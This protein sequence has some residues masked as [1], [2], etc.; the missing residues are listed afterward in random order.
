[1]VRVRDDRAA[2]LPQ[3]IALNQILLVLKLRP[4]VARRKVLR[5]GVVEEVAPLK[6]HLIPLAPGVRVVESDSVHRGDARLRAHHVLAHAV[7]AGGAARHA[8]N[9][10]EREV[11]LV[12]VV[13]QADHRQ[14]AVPAEDVDITAGQVFA[15]RLGS[16]LEIVAVADVHLAELT[17]THVS[18]RDDVDRLVALA[19]VHTRE[20]GVVA[21][22]VIH[23]DAIHRLGR[24]RL[25]GRGDILAEKLLA[26]HEDLLHLLALRLDR[27]V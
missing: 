20:F 16:R 7:T 11:L 25:D 19:V 10:L 9:I 5:A 13:E 1:M 14:A 2:V 6:G 18:V 17:L 15:A 22:L 26:V 4:A 8:Q 3:G 12:D 24:Q 21:Q 23:L 27:A